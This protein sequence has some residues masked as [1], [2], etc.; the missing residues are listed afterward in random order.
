MFIRYFIRYFLVSTNVAVLVEVVVGEL[1]F[2]KRAHLLRNL[3]S[4][5]GRI[6]M[7]VE[8]GSHR[9][10]GFS[11]IVKIMFLVKKFSFKTCFRHVMQRL[12]INYLS[13]CKLFSVSIFYLVIFI[14]YGFDEI[15]IFQ[16]FCS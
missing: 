15:S 16:T 12:V 4:V 13:M 3:T 2:F 6:G 1:E 11:L 7:H 10:I 14:K 9:R 8:R 5:Q